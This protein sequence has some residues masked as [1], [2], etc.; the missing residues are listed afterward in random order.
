MHSPLRMTLLILGLAMASAAADES[1]FKLKEGPDA[2]MVRAN[3]TGCHSAD[4]IQMN[5]R[6]LKKSGWDAEV[7]KMIKIMGA[8]VP[9]ENVARIVNYLTEF[10]G[11]D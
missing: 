8:P 11:V 10:Y 4:Y 7:R 3:C 2:V 1:T 9:E 6:F 5:S